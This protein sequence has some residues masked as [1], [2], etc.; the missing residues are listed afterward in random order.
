MRL[1]GA[2]ALLT[3]AYEVFWPKSSQESSTGSA[4]PAHRP[5]QHRP[6]YQPPP[7]PPPPSQS[8]RSSPYTPPVYQP[9]QHQPDD[10]QEDQP[11]EYYLVLRALANKE[12]DEMERCFNESREAHSRGEGAAAKD[13]SKQG[14]NHKQKMEQLN[15]EASDL[16]YLVNNRDCRPGEIDLHRLRVKEAIARTD[17]ALEEAKLRGDSEIRLI[18]GKGLHSEG[19]AAKVRPAIK[20]L[21]RKYQLAAEFDPSN[22]GVLVVELNGC[23]P[24]RHDHDLDI[25]HRRSSGRRRRASNIGA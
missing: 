16:I 18:V 9:E 7:R 3:I 24:I 13:L 6:V 21:M 10:N 4:P 17:A 14:K 2:A 5:Q 22:S 8:Y 23:P 20:G 25:S 11:N 19:G 12:R 1:L 15:K